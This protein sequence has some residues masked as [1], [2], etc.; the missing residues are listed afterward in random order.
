MTESSDQ[1]AA[2]AARAASRHAHHEAGHAVAAVARGGILEAIV[3]GTAEWTRLDDYA[4]TPGWTRHVSAPAH[5]PFVTYAGPW[6]EA[7]WEFEN[8]PGSEDFCEI[9]LLAW[10]ENSDG[11]TA[12]YERTV[13]SLEQIAKALGLG[14]VVGRA[15]EQDWEQELDDLWPV[16]CEIAMALECGEAVSHERIVEAI[17]RHRE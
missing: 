8:E 12:K 13:A 7:M 11:D 14:G 6:A 3:L 16:I 4:D 17:E 5:Q 2:I 9:L 15:W 10:A 1:I